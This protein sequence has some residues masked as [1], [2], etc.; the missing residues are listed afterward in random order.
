MILYRF[1]SFLEMQA[2]GKLGW[3]INECKA[4]HHR[5]TGTKY[6][7]PFR[8]RESDEFLSAIRTEWTCIGRVDQAAVAISANR[9]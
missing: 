8:N 1:F 6:F 4:K 5:H 3:Q 2:N 9:G 7:N